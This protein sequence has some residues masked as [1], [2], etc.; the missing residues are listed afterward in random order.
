[1]SSRFKRYCIV[2]IIVCLLIVIA[3]KNRA[4]E[5]FT[6]SSDPLLEELQT[7]FA[8]LHPKFKNVNIRKGDKSYTINKKHVYICVKDDKGRYYNR[9][10]L[11]YVTL[12]EYAHMLCDEIGHTPKFYR[13][14]DQLLEKAAR[15]GLYNPDIPPVE[16]Y[17]GH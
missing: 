4:F 10:M 16:D 11:A 3:Y 6:A 1:M 14:F 15:K 2:F 5:H 17:C 9:N 12:H 13:I 8:K 7:Q